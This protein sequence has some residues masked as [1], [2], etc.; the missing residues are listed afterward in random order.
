MSSCVVQTPLIDKLSLPFMLAFSVAAVASFGVVKGAMFGINCI[1]SMSKSLDKLEI[2]RQEREKR[3]ISQSKDLADKVQQLVSQYDEK[4]SVKYQQDKTDLE[5]QTSSIRDE[6]LANLAELSS[7]F[8]SIDLSERMALARLE[9]PKLAEKTHHHT[10]DQLYTF[11]GRLNCLDPEE[12]KNLLPLIDELDQ[13]L[14]FRVDALAIELKIAISRA[15][16]ILA[17]KLWRGKELAAMSLALRQEASYPELAD[18][19]E[20]LVAFEKDFTQEN[21]EKL[22]RVYESLQ[23]VRAIK[24]DV[25]GLDC[26]QIIDLASGFSDKTY[27]NLNQ[28]AIVSYLQGQGYNIYDEKGHMVDQATDECFI[29]LD[30]GPDYMALRRVNL[31][32]AVELRLVR[33]VA[34]QQESKVLTDYQLQK[35]KEAASKWCSLCN[36]L[37][38]AFNKIGLKTDLTVKKD[39]NEPLLV[40]VNKDLA[41]HQKQ[42]TK[43]LLQQ[44]S[45]DKS[46]EL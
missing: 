2:E 24:E 45:S 46:M 18:E 20:K 31:Q 3:E 21:F 7:E 43:K 30:L 36:A 6:I 4:L 26:Q 23:M 35:D 39:D 13:D 27:V 28:A 37:T 12:A 34:D 11:H 32:G 22:S 25:P 29:G 1:E 42:F 44:K 10:L 16:E 14:T 5:Q 38:D 8:N 41:N 15:A 33:V 9:A 40:I 19:F 17:K